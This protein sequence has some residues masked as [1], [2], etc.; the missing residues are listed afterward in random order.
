MSRWNILTTALWDFETRCFNRVNGIWSKYCKLLKKKTVSTSSSIVGRWVVVLPLPTFDLLTRLLFLFLCRH[1]RIMFLSA[2]TVDYRIPDKTLWVVS[3]T[4]HVLTRPSTIRMCQ[5]KSLQILFVFLYITVGQQLFVFQRAIL[6]YWDRTTKIT[7]KWTQY[8]CNILQHHELM[9]YKILCLNII[10]GRYVQNPIWVSLLI[11]LA[12][13]RWT[14][15]R[16]FGH[17][18]LA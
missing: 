12:Q 2:F 6:T 5:I 9:N 8:S 17:Q 18:V 14:C 11:V 4:L 10:F 1:W 13:C 15:D 3:G 16:S 7:G